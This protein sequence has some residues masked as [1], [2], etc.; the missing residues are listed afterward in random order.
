[1]KIGGGASKPRRST[2][3]VDCR[4]VEASKEAT[5]E[6]LERRRGMR[7]EARN[8]RGGESERR[9][10]REER[11]KRGE[12][13]CLAIFEMENWRWR[14]EAVGSRQRQP[15]QQELTSDD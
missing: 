15:A 2:S 6:E 7:E 4:R 12:C 14:A 5:G 13:E 10:I 8:E 3:T 9:G 1:M 11:R